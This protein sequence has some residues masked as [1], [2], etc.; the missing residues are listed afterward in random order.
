LRTGSRCEYLGPKGIRRGSGEG[1]YN[2]E[3]HSLYSSPNIARVSKS[4]RAW[5]QMEKYRTGFKILT[6]KPTGK[7]TLG[8][9]GHGWEKESI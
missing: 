3:L 5:S 8:R 1:F 6:G 2:E 7:R 4:D 9:P